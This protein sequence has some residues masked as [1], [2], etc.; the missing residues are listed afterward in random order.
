MGQKSALT[1]EMRF[2][3][4]IQKSLVVFSL[5][6]HPL[7]QEMRVCGGQLLYRPKKRT[8]SWNEMGQKSALTVE[9]RF[10]NLYIQKSLVVF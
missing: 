2:Y 7:L 3:N 1:V 9:M 10:Y 4:Y 8:G 6:G 5:E